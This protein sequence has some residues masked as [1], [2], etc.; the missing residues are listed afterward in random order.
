[1]EEVVG[2]SEDTMLGRFEGNEGK[3]VE[4]RDVGVEA[5]GPWLRGLGL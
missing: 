4:S 3:S 1:V 5:W 2:G